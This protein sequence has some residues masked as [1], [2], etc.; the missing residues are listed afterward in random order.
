ML[1]KARSNE[2]TLLGCPTHYASHQTC[3]PPSERGIATTKSSYML[4]HQWIY[5]IVFV[6]HKS[7]AYFLRLIVNPFPA[8]PCSEMGAVVTRA[9]WFITTVKTVRQLCCRFLYGLYHALRVGYGVVTKVV[10]EINNRMIISGHW[11]YRSEW[12]RI[13]DSDPFARPGCHH[14]KTGG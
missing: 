1:T 4:S 13:T 7:L 12:R 5:P 9:L 11:S 14:V 2:L 10:Q 6:Y 3:H 8:R